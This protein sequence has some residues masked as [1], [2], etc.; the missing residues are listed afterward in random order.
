MPLVT[1]TLLGG[2][3]LRIGAKVLPLSRKAEALLAYLAVTSAPAHSRSKL[4][5]LL[6][7]DTTDDDARNSLRQVLFRVRRALGRA[8]R[9]LTINGELVGLD[10]QSVQTDVATFLQLVAD[11]SDEALRSAAD[12]YRGS[13]LEGRN[14]GESAF[15][16][17]LGGERE[18]LQE[19]AVAAF[20]RL[21]AGREKRK[22]LAGGGSARLER[23]RFQPFTEKAHC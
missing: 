10:Q 11:G 12:L 20:R 15:E 4:A 17:W 7:G 3:E 5:A 8:S 22:A 16:D 18:R 23:L 19:I 6:W 14:T 1:L 21:I 13:L 9:I 2:F